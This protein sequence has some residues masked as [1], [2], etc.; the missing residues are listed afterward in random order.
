VTHRREEALALAEEVVLLDQGRVVDR[1][2]VRRLLLESLP[3]PREER[4]ENLVEVRVLRHDPEAGG[5]RVELI[6]G[7]A[8]LTLPPIPEVSPG[9]SIWAA[10]DAEE[11]LVAVAPPH[12]LSA[13]NVVAGTVEE[14]IPGQDVWLRSA[15][16]W[17]HLTPAA[18]R[19]LELAPGRRVWLVSKTQSWRVVAE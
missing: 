8:E 4:R 11:I 15:G 10:I 3:P 14:L 2:P 5:T 12:G 17:A 13:R 19:E 18:R 9:R 16:W 1:G 7:S 6:D